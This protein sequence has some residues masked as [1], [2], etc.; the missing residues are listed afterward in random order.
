MKVIHDFLNVFCGYFIRNGSFAYTQD[1]KGCQPCGCNGHG[2]PDMGYCNTTTGM[3]FCLNNTMS[4]DCEI[5]VEGYYG[6]P[7]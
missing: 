2:D 1:P 7:M 3:C 5:C 4:S 6:D